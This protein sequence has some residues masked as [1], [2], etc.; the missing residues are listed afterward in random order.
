[1]PIGLYVHVPYCRRRCPYCDF[2]SRATPGHAPSEYVAAVARQIRGFEGPDEARTLFFGGGTPSLLREADLEAILEAVRERFRCVDGMEVTIEANPDDVT[3]ERCQAWRAMGVNRLSLGVQSFD[4]DA[5]RYLGRRHDA[6]GARRACEQVAAH[7]ENWGMDLIY[8]GR[9]ADAWEATLSACAAWEPAHVSCYGLT[10][11]AGTP[12]GE[13]ADE[14]VEDDEALG[15]YRLAQAHL[16]AYRRYEVSN[17]ARAGRECGHN[18]IYW[19]N[20][21]Y[22]GFGPGAYSYLE[23]ERLRHVASIERYLADPFA[24][25]ERIRI[26]DREERLETVIQ[27]MW[28][29]D[30]LEKAYYVARFGGDVRADFGKAL[31]S[32]LAWRLISEDNTRIWPTEAGFELNNEIGLALA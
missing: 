21:E 15:L 6:A 24:I 19:H 4:E 28:L 25:E 7:F 27:H 18:L 9:P 22:A 1:M 26:S 14:A 29:A 20:E 32:L 5:L 3:V 13:R 31:D 30:G 8:G 10:Y 12:F 16:G 17:F 23:G 2:L 11:E